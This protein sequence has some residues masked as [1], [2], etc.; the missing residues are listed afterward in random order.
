MWCK[1]KANSSVRNASFQNYKYTLHTL[2]NFTLPRVFRGCHSYITSQ[3]SQGH[4]KRTSDV[5]P[6][7]SERRSEKL[8]FNPESGIVEDGILCHTCP[9]VRNQRVH[10]DS[11][12]VLQLLSQSVWHTN[13]TEFNFT[14]ISPSNNIIIINSHCRNSAKFN[15]RW[16][17]K[18]E[19]SINSPVPTVLAQFDDANETG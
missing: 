14:M 12:C 3:H 19:V 6:F 16:S 18:I 9:Q 1:Q 15:M 7:Y 10:S 4:E 8:V 11:V 2:Y 5:V 17:K 13:N